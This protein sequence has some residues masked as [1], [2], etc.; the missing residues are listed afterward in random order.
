MTSSIF[1]AAPESVAAPSTT[2][3]FGRHRVLELEKVRTELREYFVWK[4]VHCVVDIDAGCCCSSDA[5]GG[6]GVR[7]EKDCAGG[8]IVRGICVVVWGR[9]EVRRRVRSA[10]EVRDDIV[11]RSEWAMSTVRTCRGGLLHKMQS[12]GF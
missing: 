8:W 6:D 3:S 1:A 5:G 12:E 7:R 2:V 10:G 11:C 9:M 4:R